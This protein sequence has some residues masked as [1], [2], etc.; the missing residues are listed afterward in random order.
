MKI[1]SKD[2]KTIEDKISEIEEK[3]SGEIIPVILKQSDDYS[4]SRFRLAFLVSFISLGIY[5]YLPNLIDEEYA[6]WIFPF[7]YTFGYIIS[8]MNFLRKFFITD[9][10]K[11]EEVHQRAVEFFF[12]KNLHATKNR[13]ALLIL[14]SVLEKRIEILADCGINEKVSRNTWDQVMRDMQRTSKEKGVTSA[15]EM[16]VEQCGEILIKYFPHKENSGEKR[17]NEIKNTVIVKES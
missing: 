6:I 17:E 11:Q 5:Y 14:I 10:E 2:L 12:N 8:Y 3:T 4:A 1:K 7:S 9:A 16:G 13:S 15:L